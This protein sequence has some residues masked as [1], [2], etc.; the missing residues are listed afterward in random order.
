MPALAPR[1]CS[2]PG[3]PRLV[4]G[5][6]RCPDRRRD[7][8]ALRDDRKPEGP[9]WYGSAWRKA[10]QAWRVADPDRNLCVAC[11]AE[12]VYQYG[13]VT[14][15]RIP[16]RGDPTLFWDTSNWQALCYCHHNRKTASQDGGF[17]N[18]VPAAVDQPGG[19][20]AS[21]RQETAADAN[22]STVLRPAGA[23]GA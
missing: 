7:A 9:S 6:S 1:F 20:Q 13:A 11:L 12:G 22:G 21:S 3:C 16:H 23:I 15:H 5:A 10:T 18:V 2:K 4:R 8:G 14:D 17:G 19:A